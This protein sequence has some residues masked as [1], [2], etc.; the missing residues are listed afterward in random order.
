MMN[1]TEKYSHE[2][3]RE[4]L[5][6]TQDNTVRYAFCHRCRRYMPMEQFDDPCVFCGH[7]QWDLDNPLKREII[8]TRVLRQYMF[9]T[10]KHRQ[11]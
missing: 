9:E 6:Q 8:N 7:T 4:I 1:K 3:Y 5:R 2:R 10:F 11:G